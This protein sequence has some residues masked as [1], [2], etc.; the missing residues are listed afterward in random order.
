M[1]YC[2]SLRVLI[3]FLFKS[4]YE[5]YFT[6]QWKL[7]T[8]KAHLGIYLW[9]S[10]SEDCMCVLIILCFFSNHTGQAIQIYHPGTDHQMGV[11]CRFRVKKN[12]KSSQINTTSSQGE[13]TSWE[14]GSFSIAETKRRLIR[15]VG[16]D[17]LPKSM[18][19]LC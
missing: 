14:Q 4:I 8:L 12:I 7:F 18:C 11:L 19:R 1:F 6:R 16:K 13:N 5:L 10:S 9:V 17:S 15:P 2:I 3:I